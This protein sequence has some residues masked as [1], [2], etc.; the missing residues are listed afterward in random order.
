MPFFSKRKSHVCV[1]CVVKIFPI[2]SLNSIVAGKVFG[3]HHI[4]FQMAFLYIHL[5]AYAKYIMFNS[6][7]GAMN[8]KL[9]CGLPLYVCFGE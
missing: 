1:F 9:S 5:N 6:K 4:P 7:I 8:F 2:Y 3:E